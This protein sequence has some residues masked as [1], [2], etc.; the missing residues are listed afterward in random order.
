MIIVTDFSMN[1]FTIVLLS[2]K[3]VLSQLNL[4]QAISGF[5]SFTSGSMNMISFFNEFNFITD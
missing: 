3:R 4:C 1:F 5:D 2:F